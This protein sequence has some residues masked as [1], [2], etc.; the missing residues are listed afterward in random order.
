[1]KNWLIRKAPDAGKDWRQE[2][3]GTTEDEMV[4]W[5][6]R[7]DGHEF[8]QA[9][10]VGNG[11]GSLACCSPWGPK[12]SDTTEWLNWVD[13]RVQQPSGN[14]LCYALWLLVIC[15]DFYTT[16]HIFCKS[17]RKRRICPGLQNSLSDPNWRQEGC[18]RK[19]GDTC[20]KHEIYLL[21]SV[22]F[23]FRWI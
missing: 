13:S 17:T 18:W 10:G 12:E 7:L 3:K 6:H 16:C 2:E 4:G 5:H 21:P 9:P 1:M 22:L 15:N 20:E 11:Q 19:I 23:P 14:M 8:E